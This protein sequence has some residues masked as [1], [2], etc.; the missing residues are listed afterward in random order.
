MRSYLLFL[1]TAVCVGSVSFMTVGHDTGTPAGTDKW[2]LSISYQNVTLTEKGS[3]EGM[4]PIFLW[5][6]N[7][8]PISSFKMCSDQAAV[9]DVKK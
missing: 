6:S 4:M 2:S 8:L 1:I 5:D 7:S 9:P 3:D